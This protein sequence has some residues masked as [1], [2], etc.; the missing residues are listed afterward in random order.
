[1]LQTRIAANIRQLE[2]KISESGPAHLRP[3]P[4]LLTDAMD[5]LRISHRIRVIKPAGEERRAET[6]FYTLAKYHPQPAKNRVHELLVPY[7]I[8]RSLAD[9]ESHCSRVLEDIVRQSFTAAGGYKYLGKGEKTSPLDGVYGLGSESIGVE[10]KN[11]REWIYPTSGEVW[12]MVKKCLQIN[13][14]PLLVTRK[15]SYI[16][17]QTL[18]ALG[19]M[20]FEV[21]RQVFSQHVAHYLRD[22]QHTDI[23]GYKDVVAVDVG[24]N[25]HLVL[26]LQKTLPLQLGDHRT[27][28]DEMHDLLHEYAVERGLGSTEMKDQQRTEHRRDLYRALFLKEPD[29]GINDYSDGLT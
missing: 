3:E 28:W 1:M 25:P 10:V 12:I 9:M 16:A 5:N 8:Y 6:R 17:R 20:Y 19:I 15:T 11:V 2:A 14:V 22:I 13:A 18:D 27:Q 29:E 24:P 4:H 23:L 21:F 7:R 26:Y